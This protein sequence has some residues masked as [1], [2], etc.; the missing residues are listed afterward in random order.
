[1]TG[2]ELI[3]EWLKGHNLD[4]FISDITFDKINAS[5]YIDDKGIRFD[6]WDNVLEKVL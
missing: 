4:K 6:N 3:W 5:Y 1:M 2:V